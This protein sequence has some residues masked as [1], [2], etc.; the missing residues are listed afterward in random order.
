M[1]FRSKKIR[2]ELRN[3]NIQK[4]KVVYSDEG[5]KRIDKNIKEISSISFVPSVAGILMASECINDILKTNN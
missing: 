5:D 2:K 1:L 4:L 3:Q